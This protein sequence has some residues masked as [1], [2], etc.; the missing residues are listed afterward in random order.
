MDFDRIADQLVAWESFRA[1]VRPEDP[2]PFDAS[3]SDEAAELRRRAQLLRRFDAA[4]G[5][6]EHTA[7]FQTGPSRTE[8]PTVPGYRMMEVLGR[9][10]MGIVFRAWQEELEREV[11]VKFLLRS[12]RH[13]A[14][15]NLRFAQEARVLARLRHE[16]IV[17]VYEAA[18]HLGE[19]YFVMELM[20]GGSVAAERQRFGDPR[21]VSRLVAQVARAVQH[22]HKNEVVHRDLK[23][24]NILLDEL[25]RPRVSDF[26]LAKLFNTSEDPIGR[27]KIDAIDPSTPRDGN[28]LTTSNAVLGTP[29]YMAPEQLTSSQTIGPPVDIWAL[30]IILFEL[31][32][33]Q[34][35]FSPASPGGLIKAI[36]ECDPPLPRTLKPPIPA[37]LEA[38]VLKCLEKVP[39]NR[40][41]SAGALAD[42]LEL[43]LRGEAPLA[44]PD[45]RAGGALRWMRRHAALVVI[46]AVIVIAAAGVVATGITSYLNDPER[47]RESIASTLKSGRPVQLLGELGPPANHT[48]PIGS[49]TTQLSEEVHRPFYVSTHGIALIELWSDLPKRYS[50]E[51]ELRHEDNPVDGTV[52]LYFDYQ[53]SSP[54]IAQ[55]NCYVISYSD[56]GKNARQETFPDGIGSRIALSLQHFELGQ[57]GNVFDHTHRINN[58]LTNIPPS[59]APGP[60]PW[61]RLRVEVGME[62]IALH[63]IPGSQRED[64]SIRLPNSVFERKARLLRLEM[65][66]LSNYQ[67]RPPTRGSAGLYVGRSA[68]SFRHA[69]LTPL[70]VDP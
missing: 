28:A 26:G 39:I 21:S 22:A 62:A 25:G 42:D 23:P 3:D 44:Y 19:P 11:A 24:A 38:V 68:A 57:G 43:W 32:T 16:H 8:S 67:G 60:S 66:E 15:H 52:G 46:L 48:L 10:G 35:P 64:Q 30:G 59:P 45:S 27:S 2:V 54:Q 6:G 56:R 9:G 5:M 40:Y 17:P 65:P 31:L 55:A 41:A 63:W 34:R 33:G 18:L 13:S 12:P 53:N 14:A 61:R 70:S 50:L 51:V 4:F 69:V 37:A 58:Q 47:V 49:E 36:I 1:E 20:T 7:S 29:V